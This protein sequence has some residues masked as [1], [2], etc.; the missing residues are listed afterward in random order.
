[1]VDNLKGL[2]TRYNDK[3]VMENLLD[4]LVAKDGS[5]TLGCDNMSGILIE[6]WMINKLLFTFTHSLSFFFNIS[7]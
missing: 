4:D 3:E 5:E 7:Q 6:F 2:I 1:M